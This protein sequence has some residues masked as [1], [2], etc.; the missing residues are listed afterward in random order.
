MEGRFALGQDPA[1]SRA[2]WNFL[3]VSEGDLPAYVATGTRAYTDHYC[4]LWPGGNPRPYLSRNFTLPLARSQLRDPACRLWLIR[5]GDQAAGICKLVLDRDLPGSPPGRSVF[6]EKVYFI[7]SFTGR[8][9]GTALLGEIGRFAGESGRDVLWLEAMQ[10]G[11]ALAFYLKNGFVRV[12]QTR[13]PYP[14]VLPDEKM[15]WVLKREL[16]GS[17]LPSPR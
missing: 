10:K 17:G 12:S 14:E 6:I 8:G 1:D 3:P 2:A 11:P 15:M 7:R 9:M 16:K 13:I 5:E 4:H